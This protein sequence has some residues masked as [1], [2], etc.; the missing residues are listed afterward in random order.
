M[1]GV[2]VVLAG[3]AAVSQVA[4]KGAHLLADGL[5]AAPQ[6]ALNYA[7]GKAFELATESRL[8]MEGWS[9]ARN[10]TLQ[11]ANGA[12]TVMDIIAYK[13]G[14]CLL[15]EC[16]SSATAP[17]TDAQRAAHPA[18]EAGGATVMGEGKPNA[19]GGTQIPAGTRTQVV[20]P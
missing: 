13:D 16:K 4:S 11:A 20:R 14:Q 2:G 15:I 7:K 12:R 3:G 18:I 5:K 1:A 17:L 9:T 10:V 19:P 8:I 6:V